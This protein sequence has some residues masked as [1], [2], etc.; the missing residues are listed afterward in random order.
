MLTLSQREQYEA[1]V[2]SRHGTGGQTAGIW[3]ELHGN[4]FSSSQI[5]N[6][7]RKQDIA[8]GILQPSFGSGEKGTDAEQ[9]DAARLIQYLDHERGKVSYMA[10]YYEVKSTQ[11]HTVRKA[12]VRRARER[13]ARSGAS[14]TDG[15]DES[16]TPFEVVAECT[17]ATGTT[18]RTI[19][20]LSPKEQLEIGNVMCPVLKQQIGR[21]HV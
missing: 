18:T 16:R 4:T 15:V 12:D 20:T 17:D 5:N 6:N 14:V 11:L 19:A 10:L 21:A 3:N 1:G 9:S 8:Q 7:K 2:Y 13:E